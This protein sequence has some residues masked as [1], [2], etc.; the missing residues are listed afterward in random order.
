MRTRSSL[1]GLVRRARPGDSRAGIAVLLGLVL[2][3]G[4]WVLPTHDHADRTHAPDACV[5]CHSVHG[6]ESLAASPPPLPSAGPE[7]ALREVRA[8]GVS[9]ARSPLPE[10]RSRAPP[11]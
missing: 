5:V 10:P 9:P 11:G 2:A 6:Q 8:V 4:S 1:R 3:L 7:I